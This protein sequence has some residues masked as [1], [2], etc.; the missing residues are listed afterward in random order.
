MPRLL[1]RP[2]VADVPPITR[3][4]VAGLWRQATKACCLSSE[5]CQHI[6]EQLTEHRGHRARELIAA[7]KRI[8]DAARLLS[9]ISASLAPLEAVPPSMPAE[10]LEIGAYNRLAHLRVALIQSLPVLN[11]QYRRTPEDAIVL[12]QAP[13]RW[14]EEDLSHPR[15]RPGNPPIWELAAEIGWILA[16]NALEALGRSAGTSEKS[17]AVKFAALAAQ[18]MGFPGATAGALAK[19]LSKMQR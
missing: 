7:P 15:K 9:Y 11:P 4:E 6:A 8:T 14:L 17:I 19:R 5:V 2:F 16:R 10:F 18:R 13:A 12:G 3:D 1:K